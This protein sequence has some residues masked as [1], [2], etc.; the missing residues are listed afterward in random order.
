MKK[1]KILSYALSDKELVHSFKEQ[2]SKQE[3]EFEFLEHAVIEDTEAEWKKS[4]LEKI[5]VADSFVC[6]F[7]FSTWESEAVKWEVETAIQNKKNVLLVKLKSTVFMIPNYIE[8]NNIKVLEEDV[9]D[10]ANQIKANK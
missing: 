5:Q 8:E 2:M 1:K 6:L 10:I 7:G 4:V 9:T 3:N